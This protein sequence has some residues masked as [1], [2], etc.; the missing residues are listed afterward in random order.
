MYQVRDKGWSHDKEYFVCA[1]YR[2]QKGKCTSHQIKN[3]QVEEILLR[4]IRKVTAFAKDHEDEFVDLVLKKK[5]SELNQ[6]LRSQKKELD[7]SKDRIVKLDSIVQNLYE[8]S[9]EGKISAQ[10]FEKWL[11]LMMKKKFQVQI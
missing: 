4:E 10:R 9:L 11:K 1:S 7:D 5:T 6:V 3:I 2:K 8:D